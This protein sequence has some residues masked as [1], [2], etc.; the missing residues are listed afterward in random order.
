MTDLNEDRGYRLNI[1]NARL[2]LRTSLVGPYALL[3][4]SD[5]DR[6]TVVD[7]DNAT[8]EEG[9]ILSL[10]RA[11]GLEPLPLAI[12]N[13]EIQLGNLFNAEGT[14]VAFHALFADTDNLPWNKG[15]Y[16]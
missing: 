2:M 6:F 11:H 10:V 16:G 4:R 3:M 5:P 12:V 9:E 13:E 1:D 14:P 7:D 8:S 15:G